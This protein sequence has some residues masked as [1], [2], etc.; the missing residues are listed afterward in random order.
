MPYDEKFEQRKARRNGPASGQI[1]RPFPQSPALKD[2]VKPV[3]IHVRVQLDS[4]AGFDRIILS[5]RPHG[6]AVV[7]NNQKRS[8]MNREP[9]TDAC[10]NSFT[11]EVVEAVWQKA[12]TMGIY[13]TLRV[14]A[15]GWTIV[16]QDFGN[17][18]SR[19]GWEIDHIVPVSMGGGDDLSNLQPL[20]WENNRRK[21]EIQGV[22]E[23][24][25]HA[26][27]HKGRHARHAQRHHHHPPRK[28]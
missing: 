19:Y 23:E 24:R 3:E 10:G 4:K 1:R 15:W 18:R 25:Q 6:H 7:R 28:H 20:Q 12:R 27:P 11:P 9:N 13:E 26:H 17:P 16:R 2:R 8:G 5:H 22:T 21:D 14:D